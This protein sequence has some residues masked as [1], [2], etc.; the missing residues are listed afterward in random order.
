MFL[1][2]LPSLDDPD[3]NKSDDCGHWVADTGLRTLGCGHWV[4]DTGFTQVENQSL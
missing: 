1:V 3:D 2:N 4:A